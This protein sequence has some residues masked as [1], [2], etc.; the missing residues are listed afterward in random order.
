[1]PELDE[2]P[3]PGPVDDVQEAIFK[4]AQAGKSTELE[5]DDLPEPVPELDEGPRPAPVD[6]VQEAIFEAGREGAKTDVDFEQ[7]PEPGDTRPRKVVRFKKEAPPPEPAL[8]LNLNLH[9][10]RPRLS[11]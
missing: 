8:H 7:L 9:R 3:R 1:M 10:K 6:E 4:A 11:R 5:V 2:G